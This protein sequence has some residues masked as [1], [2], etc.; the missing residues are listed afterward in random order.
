MN[1]L[2]FILSF[3]LVC[4]SCVHAQKQAA[5]SLTAAPAKAAAFSELEAQMVRQ[6][7]V[8]VKRLIPDAILDIRYASEN[9]FLQVNVY[10][11]Y[12]QCY[13]Q[14][15]VAAKLAKADSVLKSL[16]PGWKFVLFDCARPVSVQQKM[17]DALQMPAAEKGKYV[18]NPKNLSV[19]NLG[20]AVDLSLAD[21]KSNYLD[22]GTDF[23]YFGELAYPFMEQ[24]LLRQGKLN[25]S[26]IDNRT[27]LRV[28]MKKA[29]FSNVPHEW[30]HFNAF[31]REVARTK[32]VRI[33]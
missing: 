3:C 18:S 33:D 1:R 32:Y 31:S 12:R 22:M 20:A 30:W 16:K 11:G 13:L 19:H 21:E 28:A 23:D 8:N 26:H 6:G 27:V 2:L 14:P 29:G 7:L 9:N 25:Q 17:W 4:F 5:H 15:D 24:T 10:G